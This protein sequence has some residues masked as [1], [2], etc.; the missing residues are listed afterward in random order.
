[1]ALNINTSPADAQKYFRGQ[2]SGK[3]QQLG[4]EALESI[5]SGAFGDPQEFL[6][7]L[8]TK[9]ELKSQMGDYLTRDLSKANSLPGQ[10]YVDEG[11]INSANKA[12]LNTAKG[13]QGPD[14]RSNVLSHG[15]MS[16]SIDGY[17]SALGTD[18]GGDPMMSA[19]RGKADKY[20]TNQNTTR[21][22][23]NAI[24][25]M[26]YQSQKLK[27]YGDFLAAAKQKELQNFQEQYQFQMN[28]A[29]QFQQ[30]QAQQEANKAQF[31]SSLF[32]WIPFVGGM[33]AGAAK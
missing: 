7:S 14:S 25:E 29:N 3:Y 32:G 31:L 18:V 5:K 15:L 12:V 30:Y 28:R 20:L 27:S 8:K 21:N 24:G 11:L 16:N 33:I 2:E 10:Q 19:F 1:M 4:P 17:A 6:D 13:I 23:Q 26:P 22:V 9:D